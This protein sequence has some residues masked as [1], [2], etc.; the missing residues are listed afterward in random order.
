MASKPPVSP[1]PINP[2]VW[3]GYRSQLLYVDAEDLNSDL[4]VCTASSL[5]H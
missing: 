5:S 4:H 3:V 1:L 2:T